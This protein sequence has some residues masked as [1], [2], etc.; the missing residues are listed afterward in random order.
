VPT[1][2]VG[3]DKNMEITFYDFQGH[4]TA[5]TEDEIHIYLFSGQPIAYIDDTSVYAY[6]GKHLGRFEDGWIRNNQG[7]YVFFTED[8]SGGPMKP[9]KSMKPMK[10]MRGMKPMMGMKQMKPMRPMKTYSWSELSVKEFFD[11]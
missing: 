2:S 4:P 9:M 11:T 8:A 1:Y 3:K 10:G 6:N 5:Y 7:N